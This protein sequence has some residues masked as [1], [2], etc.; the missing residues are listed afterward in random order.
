MPTPYREK[1]KSRPAP[2]PILPFLLPLPLVVTLLFSLAK[3]QF[4]IFSVS[5]ISIG[6][7]VL[8]GYFI[9]RAN[10]YQSQAAKRK[11]LRPNR[12]PWRFSAA[13]F[14]GVATSLVAL[15]IVKYGLLI[16]IGAGVIAFIGM[17][18]CYGVDSKTISQDISLVGV[19]R[20]ELEDAFNEAEAKIASIEAAA[21]KVQDT[22]LA[23]KLKHI[24]Q[25]S[26]GIL[27]IIAEDPKDLRRARKFLKVYLDGAQ[28]VVNK[29][30]NND[31]LRDDKT[32]ETNLNEVLNTIDKVIEEQRTKLLENDVLEL[33]V[34]IEVLQTQLKHEGII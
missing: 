8:S 11:W 5:A 24:G 18:L 21:D 13:V 29:Y 30:V 19:T 34:Q 12:T 14:S 17:V 33:D 28:K 15:F 3:N 6:L 22:A 1:I 16:S 7:Y 31:H 10:Y 4:T 20:E 25:G 27:D 32:I 23:D 26:R 9:S 2:G